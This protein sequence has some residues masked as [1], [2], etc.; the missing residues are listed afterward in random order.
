MSEAGA[1]TS[2]YELLRQQV[3]QDP[4]KAYGTALYVLGG[5]DAP[6]TGSVLLCGHDLARAGERERAH[7]LL[8]GGVGLVQ[9]RE[10]QLDS[11]A[12]VERARALKALSQPV[13]VTGLVGGVFFLWLLRRYAGG[14]S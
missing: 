6:D 13:I 4:Q 7:L 14:R 12:F 10:K 9:L 3:E 1:D 5:L 8:Q 11:R 2:K